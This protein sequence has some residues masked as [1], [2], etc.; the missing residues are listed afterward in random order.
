MTFHQAYTLWSLAP[1]GEQKQLLAV[2]A[3][4]IARGEAP[5]E[6]QVN[7]AAKQAFAAL[8]SAERALTEQVIKTIIS[9][10]HDRKEAANAVK[11]TLGEAIQYAG[12]DFVRGAFV[13][14]WDKKTK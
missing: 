4:M 6:A 9:N 11:E 1:G 14:E 12:A 5:T 8:A 10:Y 13:R 2:A 7:E 3:G